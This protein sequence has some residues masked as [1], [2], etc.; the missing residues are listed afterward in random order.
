MVM[1]VYAATQ[2]PAV[3]FVC[4][5]DDR[6]AGVVYALAALLGILFSYLGL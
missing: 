5:L 6:K 1:S 2:R 3:C 4:V